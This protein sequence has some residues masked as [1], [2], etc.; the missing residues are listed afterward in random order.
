MK[1]KRFFYS[2]SIRWRLVSHLVLLI[3][4]ILLVTWFF[5]VA[6]LDTFYELTKRRE[7][8]NVANALSQNLDSEDLTSLASDLALDGSMRII[9][10]RTVDKGN[11]LFIDVD[12]SSVSSN[13]PRRDK[14]L[15]FARLAQENGGQYLD[16]FVFDGYE[17]RNDSLGF[18]FTGGQFEYERI[19]TDNTRLVC[20]Q[21]AQN[22]RGEPCVIFLDAPLRPLNT[23]VHT[24]ELQFVWIAIILVIVASISV[25]L[26]YR[27][28]SSPLIRMTES[29]KQLAE[30]KYDT[31]FAGE[32]YLETH[33]LADTLNY[34]ATELSRVDHLQKELLANISHDLRTPLTM[35]KGYTELMRDIPDENTPENLQVVIDETERLSELVT[36][37]LD[38]SRIK[39]G[40]AQV[41]LQ[42]FDLT[43][44][45]K[46]SLKRYET[47]IRHRGYRIDFESDCAV[48][49][50]AD[51]KMILQVLYN[52]INNAIN[53]TGKERAVS[54]VQTVSEASVRISVTDT[55]EGI[56]P[57][58]MPLIWDRYYK[59]DKVH[60]RATVGTGLGLAIVK[61]ILEKHHA[62]YGVS[63][64]IGQGSTFWFELPVIPVVCEAEENS[65]MEE[66]L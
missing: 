32:G 15:E 25:V 58:E 18:W 57:E 11:T 27:R 46:E 20:V 52:L 38:L 22:A 6:M 49:V 40:N 37:L 36:D 13:Y 35:I 23:T 48:W 26:L 65:T 61:G 63:S 47:L 31:Q 56:S 66:S 60:K 39:S 30:G 12:A 7:L 34:A 10:Y 53:Y 16:R 3:L 24:L 44:A 45:V 29:A 59:V 54:V 9:V 28:I 19:E 4:V 50:N 41:Q 51:R 62:T 14:L 43:E 64:V 33:E 8:K 21:L 17:I 1:G 5:Q 55:G 2:D 42:P